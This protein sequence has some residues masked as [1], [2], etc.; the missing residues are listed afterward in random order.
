MKTAFM[1]ISIVLLLSGIVLFMREQ[2]TREELRGAQA[3]N[4]TLSNQV[5]ESRVKITE[6]TLNGIKL[7]TN[8]THRVDELLKTNTRLT[9]TSEKLGKTEAMLQAAQTQGQEC[10]KQFEVAESRIIYLQEFLR[11]K[12]AKLDRLEADLARTGNN[13][14]AREKELALVSSTLQRVEAESEALRQ[15][16]NDTHALRQQLDRV[17]RFGKPDESV[18]GINFTN[19]IE[20]GA[21]QLAARPREAKGKLLLQPDGSVRLA[22]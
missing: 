15:D 2:G 16:F 22:P 5:W 8:L 19:E 21:S 3:Q 14:R 12:Q 13:L 17:K 6:L 18:G 9:T 7:D 11:E 20:R 10:Q 1:F 4:T